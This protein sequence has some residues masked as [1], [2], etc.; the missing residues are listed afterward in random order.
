MLIRNCLNIGLCRE[1]LAAA[2]VPLL[3]ISRVSRVQ[4]EPI[5]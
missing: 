4:M 2:A 5:I 1:M 3:A